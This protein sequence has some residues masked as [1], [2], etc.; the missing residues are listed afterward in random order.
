MATAEVSSVEPG[1]RDWQDWVDITAPSTEG[2]YYYGVCVDS[3]SGESDTTN[4]CGHS[5]F[6]VPVPLPRPDVVVQTPSV[7]DAILETG[8]AFTLS[9][10]V[11]NEG[12]WQSHPTTVRYYRSQEGTRTI[13][14]DHGA[15]GSQAPKP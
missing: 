1:E 14:E 2:T 8:E 12:N 10:T 15:R 9:A 13:R 7:D 3:V 6:E 4:H 5:S 11:A